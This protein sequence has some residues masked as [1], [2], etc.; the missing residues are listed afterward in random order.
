VDPPNEGTSLVTQTG[1]SSCGLVFLE[2]RVSNGGVQGGILQM[3]FWQSG[4]SVGRAVPATGSQT[5]IPGLEFGR[6]LFG[7]RRLLEE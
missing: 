7:E 4:Q 3:P 5:R 6:L 2:L 1:P